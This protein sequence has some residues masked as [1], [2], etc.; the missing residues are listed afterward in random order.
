VTAL[1]RALADLDTGMRL[2]AAWALKELG[3]AAA[4]LQALTALLNTL[5]D[6]DADVRETAASAFQRLSSY[7]RLP[8]RSAMVKLVLPLTRSNDATSRDV[9]YVSLRNLLA[10]EPVADMS[11]ALAGLSE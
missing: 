4:T 9:G 2:A 7:V 3:A 5:A 8:E 11:P 10:T 6:P 1:L